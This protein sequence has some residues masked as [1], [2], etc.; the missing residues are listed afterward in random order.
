M[1]ALSPEQ[2]ARMEEMRSLSPEERRAI[3]QARMED[4]AVQQKMVERV[5]NDL[6]TS[7]PEQ[8]IK[9]KRDRRQMMQASQQQGRGNS[10]GPR[11]Q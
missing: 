2:R 3:M 1:E 4:P 5:L 8:M 9:R 11:M 6:R 10:G 7:T